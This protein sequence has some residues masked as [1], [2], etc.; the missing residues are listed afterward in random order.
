MALS[1]LCALATAPA[2]LQAQAR[3]SMLSRETVAVVPTLQVITI[4]DAAQNSCYLLFTIDTSLST[5]NRVDA[6][7]PD[8]AGAAARRDH[9]FA[10][11][12]RAYEQSF[13]SLFVGTPANALPYQF[14]AQKIQADFERVVRDEELTRL[15]AQLERVLA[16][17]KIAVSG[18][19]PCGPEQAAAGTTGR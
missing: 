8:V 12:N 9:R 13:G 10:D 15:E 2:S 18:P 4:R 14:E 5:A 7:T 1:L 17:P 3:F 11:L 19:A 6:Q 16:A